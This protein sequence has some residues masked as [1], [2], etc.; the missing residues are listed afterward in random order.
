MERGV[1]VDVLRPVY[2]ATTGKGYFDPGAS[3][4]YG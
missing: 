1:V 2:S 4:H 3:N